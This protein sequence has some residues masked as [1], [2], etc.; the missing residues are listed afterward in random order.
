MTKCWF[1]YKTVIVT[2]ASSGIGKE[3]AKRLILDHDCTVYAIARG[4]ERLKE[5]QG[6][7]GEK[8]DKYII[9]TF[10]EHRSLIV[11]AEHPD[12]SKNTCLYQHQKNISPESQYSFAEGSYA[13]ASVRFPGQRSG[14]RRPEA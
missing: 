12:I 2:G 7:L 8:A 11:I 14:L 1:D 6:E 13:P 5:A 10:I 9:S 4:V 3:I